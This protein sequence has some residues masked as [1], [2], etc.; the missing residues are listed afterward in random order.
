MESRT[1]EQLMELHQ[2]G[3][4]EAFEVLYRRRSETISH[5]IHN[6][7]YS[8]APSLV[9]DAPDIL[10]DVFT[11]IFSYRHKFIGGTMVMPW[12]I[13][14]ADRLTKNHIKFERR[15]RRDKRRTTS[16][17]SP[18]S[19]S[20]EVL[21]NSEDCT[22]RKGTL[23]DAP[24]WLAVETPDSTLDLEATEAIT[25]KAGKCLGMLPPS[26]QQVVRLRYFDGLKSQEIADLLGVPKTTVDWRLRQSM[27]LIRGGEPAGA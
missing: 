13:T 16:L 5:L 8:R 15:Q 10:Q 17:E 4:D 21:E 3:N 25:S 1:D 20:Q 18:F 22:R 2:A 11:W 26:Y 14:T 19:G 7:L 27:S 6:I 9:S 12:L 23:G 24:H